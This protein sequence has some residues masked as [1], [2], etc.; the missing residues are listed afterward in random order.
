MMNSYYFIYVA[1]SC[2]GH[3]VAI[4]PKEQSVKAFGYIQNDSRAKFMFIYEGEWDCVG[5]IPAMSKLN[6]IINGESLI[7]KN[8]KDI[9]SYCHFP[10]NSSDCQNSHP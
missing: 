6:L 10:K 5:E 8:K 1:G 4:F 3:C 2:G 7:L 9:C